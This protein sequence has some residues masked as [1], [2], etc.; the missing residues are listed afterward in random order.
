MIPYLLMFAAPAVYALTGA[1]RSKYIF[2]LIACGYWL[3]IGF[4][5]QIGM[6]WNNYYYKYLYEADFWHGLVN[7]EPGYQILNW[8]G[9]QTGG[10]L[11][12]VDAIGGLIFCLGYFSVARR[13]REPFLAIVVSTPLLVVAFAMSGLRQSISLG[14]IFYLFATWNERSTL[15]R[16][17]IV[18]LATLFHFSA[19]FVLIF[20]AAATNLPLIVRSVAS[21]VV[22]G[23]VVSVIKLAPDSMEAYSNLYV[24]G[25]RTMS[26]PGAV[27]E[28][29]VLAL[30]GLFL[31]LL[32]EPWRNVIGE[33]RLY[34]YLAWASLAAMPF[35]LISS[36]AA[37]RFALYFWPM[38]MY[39]ASGAPALIE[40]P[41]GRAFCRSLLVG[42]SLAVL[43]GWLLLAN[44]S[45]A[46]LPYQNWLLQPAGA[47]L[48]RHRFMH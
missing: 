3:M 21:I 41:T 43:I 25:Q 18:V 17:S 36:V 40:S 47:P 29:G 16:V 37:Y 1:T 48:L 35:I 23:L 12:L 15:M 46:W 22:A 44:N 14:I 10:G 31:I 42:C 5:Y 33:N 38:A 30:A 6:D 28:V 4:R 39:V 24:T 32:R 26:A 19:I 13:C 2:R 9:H 20:V 8:F 11:I 7:R 27:V 45:A 34:F